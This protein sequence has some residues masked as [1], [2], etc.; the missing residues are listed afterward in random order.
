MDTKK[1]PDPN[2]NIN[3]EPNKNISPEKK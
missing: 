3:P 1:L 2:K